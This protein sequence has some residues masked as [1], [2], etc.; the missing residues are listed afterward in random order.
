MNPLDTL[1]EL[2]TSFPGIGKRQAERFVYHLL[3]QTKEFRT[4][5]AQTITELDNTVATCDYCKRFFTIK[6][7]QHD[8]ACSICSNATRDT[9]LLMVVASD[10]DF[11]NIEQSGNYK[12]LYFIL[13]GTVPV[14]DKQP[15]QKIRIAELKKRLQDKRL[16]ELILALSTNPEGENTREYI[17]RELKTLQKEKNLTITTLGRG[18]SAGAELEYSDPETLKG[19]LANRQ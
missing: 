9:A 19:A 8:T 5:L 17:M 6:E 7:S 11:H 1:K 4:Q 12:G 10:T 13:G 2:F 15:A 14:L 16:K 3:R 18:L